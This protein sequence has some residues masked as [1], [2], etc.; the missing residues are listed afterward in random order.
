M[1]ELSCSYSHPD[2]DDDWMWEEDAY[3]E[4]SIEG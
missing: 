2:D 4:S 3:I 1:S